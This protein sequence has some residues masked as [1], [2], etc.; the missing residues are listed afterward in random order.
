MISI[1]GGHVALVSAAAKG[2]RMR[3][4][5]TQ[6]LSHINGRCTRAA[7]ESPTNN[8]INPSVVHKTDWFLKGKWNLNKRRGGERMA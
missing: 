3:A 7:F 8:R 6:G 2:D 1:I 5:G 4:L